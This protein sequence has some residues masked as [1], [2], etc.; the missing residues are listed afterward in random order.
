MKLGNYSLL[1]GNYITRHKNGNLRSEISTSKGYM[2]GFKRYYPNG[3]LKFEI[4]VSE[5]C[6]APLQHCIKEYK[7]DGS[8]KRESHTYL[9]RD[10]TGSSE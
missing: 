4:I 3:V 6:G 9:P 10:K 8:L 2:T 7:K 1:N 5:D